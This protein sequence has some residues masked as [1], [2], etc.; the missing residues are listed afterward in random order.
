MLL[1]ETCQTLP[2][3]TGGDIVISTDGEQ[4][5]AVFTCDLGSSIFGQSTLNCRTDGSWD[6]TQPECGNLKY[7]S[8]L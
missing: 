7:T 6:F 1:S 8:I 3:I 5:Q 4:T 2:T